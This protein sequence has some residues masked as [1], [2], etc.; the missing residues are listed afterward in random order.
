MHDSTLSAMNPPRFIALVGGSGSG[1]S[2]LAQ[3]L[4]HDLG[5]DAVLLALDDFY[6]DLGHVPEPQREQVNFDDPKAIDWDALRVVLECL[7]RGEPAR[8]P[9]YDFATHT[10]HAATRTLA[11]TRV[12]LLDGLWLLHHAWLREKFSLS[13]FVDCP[14]EERMR[15]R[16]ER[17]VLTRG[18]T[19]DSV[20]RQFAD[21]VQPMHARFVEPQ[22]LWATHCVHSPLA[23]PQHAQLLAACLGK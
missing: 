5:H 3:K 22:R 13:V 8:I 17:D 15:R 9:V 12:I 6:R 16:V 19:Q 7:E 21:H 14:E 10:R 4:L 2:W 1:K 18:R 23:D 20:L 11:S